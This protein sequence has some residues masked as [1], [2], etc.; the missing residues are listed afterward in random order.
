VD[1]LLR[2]IPRYTLR[3][4]RKHPMFV[5]RELIEKLIDGMRLAG[6]PEQPVMLSSNTR[7]LSKSAADAVIRDPPLA[8]FPA[9]LSDRINCASIR[10]TAPA[11]RI[12]QNR[13][14]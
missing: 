10:R 7:P 8:A 11:V 13:D 14:G 5:K 4:L 3:A 12:R 9:K 6:L 1:E 2:L